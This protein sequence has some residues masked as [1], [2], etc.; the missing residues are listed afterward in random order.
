MIALTW[1]LFKRDGLA[2]EWQILLAALT[3]AVAAMSAV[4]FF[5]SRVNLALTQEAHGMLAAD[6]SISS[7][8]ALPDGYTQTA[9]Q[10]GLSLANSAQFPTM[11][12]GSIGSKLVTLKAISTS[13]PLRGKMTMLDPDGNTEVSAKGAPLPGTAW[14]DSRL[15]KEL[16]LRLTNTIQL[17][18]LK[19]TVVGVIVKE[20]DNAVNLMNFTPRVLINIDDLPKT[21]LVVE[22]SR[23]RYRLM[24]A[25][26][27]SAVKTF[28]EQITPQLQRGEQLESLDNARP[29]LKSA[30][31]RARQ[32]M[33]LTAL[34]SVALAAAAIGL[35]AR[36]YS[37]RHIDAVAIMA[38]IGVSRRK[39]LMI[40]GSQWLL[41]GLT[42][43]I[44]GAALGYFAQGPL[45]KMLA[46]AFS[47]QLPT[48]GVGPAFIASTCGLILLLGFGWPSLSV[49]LRT[50]GLH[51]LRREFGATPLS[52][53]IV[54]A[55]MVLALLTLLWLQTSQ[56]QLAIY[57]LLGFG[58]MALL[59]YAG[60]AAL[61][62]LINRIKRRLP[63]DFR[64]AVSGLSRHRGLTLTQTASLALSAMALLT[65][66]V[67]RTQ[68]MEN[69]QQSLP[70]DAPN[71]FFINIQPDQRAI[72]TETFQKAGIDHVAMQPMVRGR[73]MKLNDKP[74]S[75]DEFKDER[76]RNLAE[77]EF[78][79]SSNTSLAS[80]N[81]ITAGSWFKNSSDVG[82]SVEEGLAET[83][84]MKLG[85]QLS[86]DVA[87]TLI[88][89]KITSLRKVRWDSFKPN[90][91]VLASPGLLEQQPTSYISALYIPADKSGS[92]ETLIR[93]LPNLTAIDVT[94][95][96]ANVK[97]LI[98]RV[99]SVVE[100]LFLFSLASG[101]VVLYASLA[102]SQDER[103]AEIALLRTLGSRQKQIWMSLVTETLLI[104]AIAGLL[105]ATGAN[106]LSFTVSH[107]LLQLP[108]SPSYLSFFWGVVGCA[109][110]TLLFTW[111]WARKLM[112][113]SPALVLRSA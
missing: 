27:E 64:V 44:L 89:A 25:G 7:D 95:V 12:I 22:G 86:F 84:H 35:A 26:P 66:T 53:W 31:E 8:H 104:G 99:S 103:R 65:L 88:T 15:M 30:L 105:A 2:G 83:L 43:C 62:W 13:Y 112:R 19:V 85:A 96:M 52:V 72:V 21:G 11:A 73:W 70:A 18:E 41:I 23:V 54:I 80:D 29:E 42:G 90:F 106:L 101:I 40:F 24:L 20:P 56:L 79:L 81:L 69:W 33:A 36:R 4:G 109:G 50:P 58:V 75:V 45:A 34:A 102:I 9:N 3:I 107:W 77:R 97:Q 16:D 76:A 57:A 82:W 78:N 38:C 63:P 108:W 92:V 32:F 68:L 60:G 47:G 59:G 91:F 51:A 5:S 100:Y 67:V 17:G 74:V 14:V 1:R 46:P 10:A 113:T 71:H 49:L 93:Q 39:L 28:T 87:G 61:L 110:L 55:S 37:L 94:A 6:V 111:P 48:A 98:D